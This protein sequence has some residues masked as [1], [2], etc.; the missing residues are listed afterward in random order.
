MRAKKA[1][2]LFVIAMSI[3]ATVTSI[4]LSTNWGAAL[5]TRLAVWAGIV[6][7]EEIDTQ[8]ERELASLRYPQTRALMK[9]LVM[10]QIAEHAREARLES[11]R[12][13]T[14]VGQQVPLPRVALDDHDLPPRLAL[15]QLPADGARPVLAGESGAF[16]LNRDWL[17]AAALF[18]LTILAIVV[19]R[20]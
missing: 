6:P 5:G 12:D 18:G 10:E 7:V 9:T 4:T 14:L 3:T 17:A 8:I 19:R 11:L 1:I 16:D 20:R 2:S 15:G 13:P